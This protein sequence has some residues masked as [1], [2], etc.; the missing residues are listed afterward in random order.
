[1]NRKIAESV[2]AVLDQISAMLDELNE[3]QFSF[4]LDVLSGASLGEHVRHVIEF[5]QE[6]SRG[7]QTGCIDYDARRRDK[8]I[9]TQR[10]Y[11]IIKLREVAASLKT[12]NKPLRLAYADKSSGVEC[13]IVTNYER[14]LIYNLEHT[15]H[16]M[17]LMR[18]GVQLVAG[19]PLADHFGVAK[20]T[21]EY[22]QAQCAQ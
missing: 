22:R 16:H 20:S 18:I 7:Y 4:K 8:A 21:I 1:M 5:F 15:V 9:E 14:E 2:T 19:I 6:L 3:E 11:A 13:E 12:D 10:T 17:A